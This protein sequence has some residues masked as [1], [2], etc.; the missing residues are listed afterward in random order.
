MGR[1]IQ[2]LVILCVLALIGC[3]APPAEPMVPTANGV[4]RVIET[5]SVSVGDTVTV[6]LYVNI[7]EGQTYYLGEESVPDEFEVLDRETDKSHK[8][9]F[10][11][12]QNAAST[13]YEYNLK[14]TTA[15]AFNFVGEYVVEGMDNPAAIMGDTTVNVK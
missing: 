14:A 8:I 2:L 9:K 11:K 4:T 6:K 5:S 1:L 13:V 7:N 12:I 3:A 10:I 15:G